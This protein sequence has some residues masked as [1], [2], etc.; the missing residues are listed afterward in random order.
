MRTAD[1]VACIA[2]CP[3]F[4]T[5]VQTMVYSVAVAGPALPVL[6]A[7]GAT[8]CTDVTGFGVLGH[9]VEMAKA[10]K[11]TALQTVRL[12]AHVLVLP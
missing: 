3:S 12:I 11:V 10:S 6:R 1:S 8:A 7:S 4:R 2:P 9:L 5:F